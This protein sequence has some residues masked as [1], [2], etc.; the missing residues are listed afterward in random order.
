MG[1]L[2]GGGEVVSKMANHGGV[3]GPFCISMHALQSDFIV[4]IR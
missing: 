2:G 3:C 4:V 1:D